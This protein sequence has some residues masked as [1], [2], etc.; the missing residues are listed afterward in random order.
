MLPTR[1]RPA[2]QVSEAVAGATGEIGRRLVE[3]LATKQDLQ[4]LSVKVG[5]PASAWGG[6]WLRSI[7]GAPARALQTWH[8]LAL[9]RSQLPANAWSLHTPV[10]GSSLPTVCCRGGAPGDALQVH[11]RVS[12]DEVE[13][14]LRAHKAALAPPPAPA[15][16]PKGPGAGRGSAATARCIQHHCKAATREVQ[17]GLAG[18][19]LPPS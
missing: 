15:A 10:A 14:M 2:P 4:T 5:V 17:G 9:Q 16:D 1:A 6:S 11:S 13:R 12:R 18:I 19:P 8:V 7:A 3:R